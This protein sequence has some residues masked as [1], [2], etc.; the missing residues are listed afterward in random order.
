MVLSFPLPY[1]DELLYS[2]IA[3]Y[4]L[5][6]GKKTTRIVGE[7]FQKNHINNAFSLPTGISYLSS[8]ISISAEEII[9][10][11][12]LFPYYTYF[13]ND[14][15][16]QTIFSYMLT[17]THNIYRSLGLLGCKI[18]IGIT[19]MCC[20]ECIQEDINIYGEPYWHR[21]HQL[22]EVLICAKH[23]RRLISSCELC[24]YSL[25][26]VTNYDYHVTPTHCLQGHEIE[27]IDDIEE[28][29]HHRKF[30]ENSVYILN[31]NRQSLGIDDCR[32]KYLILMGNRGLASNYNS[33][34]LK[35]TVESFNDYYE[36]F[37]ECINVDK[38]NLEVKGWLIA[39]LNHK[40]RKK[41]HP[42]YHLLL[43]G[44]LCESVN[45]F[46]G[47]EKFNPFGEGP[48][49]CF[50]KF[51]AYF[52]QNVILDVR[53]DFQNRKNAI[54]SCEHCG[55]TYLASVAGIKKYRYYRVTEYGAIFKTRLEELFSRLNI[56]S[57]SKACGINYYTVKRFHEIYKETGSC[58]TIDST[59][60]SYQ[61]RRNVIIEYLKENPNVTRSEV[62]K[63]LAKEY[64]WLE[65]FDRV[66]LGQVIP[67]RLTK[68]PPGSKNRGKVNWKQRDLELSKKLELRNQESLR[69]YGK[70]LAPNG[71]KRIIGKANYEINL[72]KLP[73]TKSIV[74]TLF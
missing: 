70:S 7:L 37:F 61:H 1:P 46:L 44:F 22:P 10:K 13:S 63:L 51:C 20:P 40:S 32:N 35:P 2:A 74:V 14:D 19:L 42:V 33:V 16:R 36:D 9:Y 45:E 56:S 64:L 59:E 26:E 21:I 27:S 66:W 43:I 18:P 71:I 23:Y 3:R 8:K 47:A 52:N 57:V 73:R 55:F 31:S 48:W 30:V 28:S 34:L 6:C 38:P 67:K 62:K 54:F 68:K 39:T 60:L 65:K 17:D 12:T 49:K 24:G 41:M 4:K 53:N 50:N 15:F 69:L 72:H 25:I 58:N 11:H 29:I 5:R